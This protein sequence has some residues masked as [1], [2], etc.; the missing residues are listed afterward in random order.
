MRKKKESK[1]RKSNKPELKQQGLFDFIKQIQNIKDPEYYNNL[2]ESEQKMFKLDL[3]LILRGLSMNPEFVDI[4][5]FFYKYLDIIPPA[6]FYTILAN[7]YPKHRYG[8]FYKWI[9]S[10][11]ASEKEKNR[12][13]L[14]E[15]LGKKYEISIAEAKSCLTTFFSSSEG[16]EE[17]FSVIRGFGMD[18]KEV[19]RMLK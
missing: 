7:V 3:F 10:G 11:K 12:D 1:S 18:D 5:A 15:M 2:S 13:K 8:E 9:K 4:A 17:L 6:Q 19:E 14:I 16:K